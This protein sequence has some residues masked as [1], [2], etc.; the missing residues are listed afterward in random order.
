MHYAARMLSVNT[1]L[2]WSKVDVRSPD[3]CWPWFGRIDRGGYGEYRQQV[4]G[5]RTYRRA[6]RVAYELAVGPTVLTIDHLCHT[7][8]AACSGGVTC[9]HRRCC[10][11]THM[12]PVT[13]IEN[14]KRGRLPQGLPDSVWLDDAVARY[15]QESLLSIAASYG[16][17]RETVKRGLLRRGVVVLP[18]GRASH[19]GS[20]S[21]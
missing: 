21:R 15:P 5:H 12:E 20:T 19:R 3:E 14:Y 6:H 11:P 7:F 17:H 8:D 1:D 10:N 2:F 13:A 16:L 18:R 9:L 4:D